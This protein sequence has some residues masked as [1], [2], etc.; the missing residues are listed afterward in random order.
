MFCIYLVDIFL[1]S[2]KQ[3][4][5]VLTVFILAFV[6]VEFTGRYVQSRFEENV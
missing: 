1:N 4:I 3:S 2:F 5:G 6:L